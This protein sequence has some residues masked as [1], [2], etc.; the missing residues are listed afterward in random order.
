MA[1]PEIPLTDE[2]LE[3]IAQLAGFGLTQAQIAAVI[4]MSPDTFLRRKK[5]R[6]EVV[7]ALEAGKAKA[8]AKVGEA[9]YTRAITGD[10]SA[11]RWYEMTRAGRS[12]QQR[13]TNI[14]G[15]IPAE[16]E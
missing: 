6:P 1:R 13:V 15:E 9:L 8:E 10:V 2:H 5:T 11:I 14:S 3:Q 4:G 12:E 7:R 16:R